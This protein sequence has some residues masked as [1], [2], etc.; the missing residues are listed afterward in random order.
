MLLRLA[1]IAEWIGGVVDGDGSI[2]ISDLAKIEEAQPGQLSFIS[3]PKYEKFAETTRASALL[4]GQ[5]FP[6]V[7]IPVIR[8]DDPYYAFLILV[9]RFHEQRPSVDPGVHPSAIVGE[10]SSIGE[11]A[12][13]GAC[14]VI[15]RSCHIGAGTVIYPGAV[16]DDEVEIGCNSTIYAN[17]SIGRGCRIGRDVIIHMG[18]VIGADGFGFVFKDNRYHKLPQMGI[19]VVEDDV[20]IGA[21]TTIDRATLGQT[22]IGRGSKLDNLI[23]V[24][25]NVQIGAHTALAAQV[26][27][28]G[29]AKIGNYVRLGGQAGLVGHITVEDGAT[30]GAQA[31]VTKTVPAGIFVSGYPAREHMRAKREEASLTKLPAL[32]K[33]VRKLEAELAEL[34]EKLGGESGES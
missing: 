16:I 30:V 11:G 3:N 26:G 33:K 17:V 1:E 34:R 28:S 22:V 20:E 7:P 18:A 9:K 24:A 15:G 27:I 8:V 12:A 23:M 25:H 14:A 19:V 29:S 6:R 21:N 5:D 32:L 2:E 13:V 31:G 10:G 4:V